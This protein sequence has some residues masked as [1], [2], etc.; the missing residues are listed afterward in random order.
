MKEAFWGYFIIAF[1]AVIMAVLFL[2]NRLTT[3]S[4]EDFYLTREVLEYSMLDAVDYGSYRTTG[5]IV[6][7]RE[8]FQ[9]VFI[10][11]FAESVTNNKSYTIEFYDIVEDPPK[12]TVRIRTSSGTTTIKSDSLSFS[13]DTLMSGILESR[14]HTSSSTSVVE[15][16]LK[17]LEEEGDAG[18]CGYESHYLVAYNYINALPNSNPN[19]GILLKRLEDCKKLGF[20]QSKAGSLKAFTPGQ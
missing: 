1:G 8:K 15:Q 12:A 14:I 4:E 19:K 5:R 20:T 3:T 17:D 16:M 18:K 6:M 13:I 9:E 11:R 10:R 7:S 2:T